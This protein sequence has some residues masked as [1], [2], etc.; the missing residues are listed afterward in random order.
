[1]F[2]FP[3]DFDHLAALAELLSRWVLRL[4][5]AIGADSGGLPSS[6]GRHRSPRVR[7]RMYG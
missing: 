1:M 6:P 2:F 4:G 7:A 5:R 3:D